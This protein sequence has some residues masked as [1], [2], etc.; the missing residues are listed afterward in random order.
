MNPSLPL[1]CKK[2]QGKGFHP[3]RRFTW[4]FSRK[5]P[6]WGH[7]S[8]QCLGLKTSPVSLSPSHLFVPH[9]ECV[10]TL[11]WFSYRGVLGIILAVFV[12]SRLI[13][14]DLRSQLKCPL[15]HVMR[16]QYWLLQVAAFLALGLWG[17]TLHICFPQWRAL[18]T[19]GNLKDQT[20]QAGIFSSVD[21]CWYFR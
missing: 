7:L 10:H 15:L 3:D 1:W 9:P 20:V 17:Q 5:P 14:P 4:N 2:S 11:V 6:S 18:H 8:S 16:E 13:N 21:L 12:H 19:W